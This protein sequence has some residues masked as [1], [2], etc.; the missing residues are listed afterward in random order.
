[1][2]PIEQQIRQIKLLLIAYMCLFVFSLWWVNSKFEPIYN[3]IDNF[4][5]I[6]ETEK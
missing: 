1:M 4:E 2:N 6:D 3:F 5:I